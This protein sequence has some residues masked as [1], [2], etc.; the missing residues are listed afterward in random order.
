M[1]VCV[2][3][4]MY[5]VFQWIRSTNW[6]KPQRLSALHCSNIFLML[7]W[8]SMTYNVLL[9]LMSTR[10][11][12]HADTTIERVRIVFHGCNKWPRLLP[13]WLKLGFV[14]CWPTPLSGICLTAPARFQP[15]CWSSFPVHVHHVGRRSKVKLRVTY[16]SL[17]VS[18]R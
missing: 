3:V 1:R 12:F 11:R 17:R 10:H 15:F 4:C 14:E 2:C 13:C 8:V 7:S 18:V 9:P 16:A 5:L 6:Y